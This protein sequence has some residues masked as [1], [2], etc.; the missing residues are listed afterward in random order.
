MKHEN[1]GKTIIDELRLCYVAEPTFLE[2]LFH[3]DFGER[4]TFDGIDVVRIV[5]QHFQYYYTLHL[6]KTLVGSLYFGR[7]GDVSDYLWLKVDNRILYEQQQLQSLLHLFQEI[8]PV[9]FNNITQLDLAKDFKKNIVYAIT[10]LIRNKEI[11]T[12][13]N[14]KVVKDRKKILDELMIAYGVSLERLR[15]PSLKICQAEAVHNKSKGVTI[16]AYNKGAELQHSKKEYISNFYGNPKTLHRL[17]V[18]LNSNEIRD[19]YRKVKRVEVVDDVFDIDLLTEMY[20]YHLG[21]VLRFTQGRTTIPW[22]KILALPTQ[23][24]NIP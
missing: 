8:F 11:K 21:S 17:E 22:H 3:L 18:R 2:T 19:F 4:I 5:A 1:L 12:I 7:Y 9:Q 24:N 20:F 10:K 13:I 14:G 15:N 23:D 6:N 16:Q